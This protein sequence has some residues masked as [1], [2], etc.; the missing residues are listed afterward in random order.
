MATD[1]SSIE[2][3]IFLLQAVVNGEAWEHSWYVPRW[4]DPDP[5]R[6]DGAVY[7]I[8][9]RKIPNLGVYRVKGFY[10]E[11]KVPAVL[12]VDEQ[13]DAERFRWL[14]DFAINH[15][16]IDRGTPYVVYGIGMGDCE[17]AVASEIRGMIDAAMARDK[18][19]I[20][21]QLQRTDGDKDAKATKAAKA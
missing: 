19:W 4:G 6:L 2:P 21:A 20:A 3:D 1:E 9:G 7:E 11:P 12:P 8:D 13:R 5:R 16:E 15:E 14:C 17:P 18:H 10:A